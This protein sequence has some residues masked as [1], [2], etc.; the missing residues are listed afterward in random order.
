MRTHL[1]FARR[2][3][4][5]LGL[6]CLLAVLPVALPVSAW[7]RPAVEL[8]QDVTVSGSRVTLGDL[9]SD[10]GDAAGVVVARVQPG[11]MVVLDATQV[12]V[13]ARSN[14][15]DWG[16]PANLRRISVQSSMA[17]PEAARPD[18][19]PVHTAQVLTYLHSLNAGDVVHAEDLTW[20]HDAVAGADAPRNPEA[21]IGM[22]AR[23]PLREGDPVSLR[24]ISAPMVIR[25]DDVIAVTFSQDGLSLTLQAK[26]LAD[27]AAGQPVSVINPASK[28]IIQAIAAGP[29]QAM[30]GPAADQFKAAVR[31]SSNLSDPS[32]LAL[33]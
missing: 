33:R 13:I 7:A 32:R 21:V 10:A 17:S 19:K 1:S 12:Q 11:Q 3:W 29:G 14:G 18:R 24:D 31:L 15:V 20:S 5:A 23:R 9:F 8:Q 28:K 25:K 4:R 27:A 30:V 2:V 16:N 6:A 22:A 26:A